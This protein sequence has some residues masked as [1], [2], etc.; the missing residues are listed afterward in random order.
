M[1]HLF[2]FQVVMSGKYLHYDLVFP[3][4]FCNLVI[5]LVLE[6]IYIE[7]IVWMC[8]VLMCVSMA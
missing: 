8:K 1:E 4:T 2:F 6:Y 3:L 7:V 5:T